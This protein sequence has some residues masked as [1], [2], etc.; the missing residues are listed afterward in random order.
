MT[1][2]TTTRTLLQL[3]L[4]DGGSVGGV[5]RGKVSDKWLKGRGFKSHQD[6]S[7]VI[8]LSKLF[9]LVVLKPT[10]PSIPSG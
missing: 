5:V 8:T 3:Q 4:L 10:Q 6:C 2:A 1:T 9:T 7:R